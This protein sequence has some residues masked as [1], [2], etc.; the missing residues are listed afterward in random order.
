MKK[1]LFSVLMFSALFMIA[2]CGSK[3]NSGEAAAEAEVAKVE[4]ADPAIVYGEGVDLT[5]YFSPVSVSQ[6]A[7]YEDKSTGNYYH[8]LSVN[9]KI[10]VN[11]KP[12][13]KG[14]HGLADKY[15]EIHGPK[16]GFSVKF[17]DEGGSTIAEGNDWKN[18]KDISEGSTIS[19]DIKSNDKDILK[20]DAESKLAKVKKIEVSISTS[21][22]ELANDAE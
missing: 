8:R 5:S 2:S 17:C 18:S 9:V 22:A 6:P 4:F 1:V 21:N 10:K 7:I 13:L 12:N 16:V 11:K 19:L 20:E 15:P 3:S 14:T